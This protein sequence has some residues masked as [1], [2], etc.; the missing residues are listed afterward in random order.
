[1][2]ACHH[3]KYEEVKLLLKCGASRHVRGAHGFNALGQCAMSSSVAC[4]RLLLGAP[5]NVHYT[6]EQLNERTEG[7][8]LLHYVVQAGYVPLCKLL[9]ASGAD[10]RIRTASGDTCADIARRFWPGRR[11]LAS[12]FD[13]DTAQAP[14]GP[15]SCSFCEKTDGKLRACSVCHS[16]LYCSRDCQ[17]AHWQAHKPNCLSPSDVSKA[18]V[19]DLSVHLT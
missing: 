13:P 12:L 5:P 1:M 4:M 11:D 3:S 10:P 7:F 19:D 15:T 2:L 16:V 14:L 18:A 17:R 9:I 8:T 6:L